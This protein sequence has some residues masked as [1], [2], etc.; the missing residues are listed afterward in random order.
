MLKLTIHNIHNIYFL[1]V[2]VAEVEAEEVM[3]VEVG[4]MVGV[5]MVEVEVEGHPQEEQTTEL[6]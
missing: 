2:V 1:G 6:L 4:V 3:E 5:V